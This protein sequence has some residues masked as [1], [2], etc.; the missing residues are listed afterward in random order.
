M[1]YGNLRIRVCNYFIYAIFC[2]FITNLPAKAAVCQLQG[3][4]IVCKITNEA[5]C[6]QVNDYPYARNLFCPASFSSAQTMLN[7]LVPFINYA[8]KIN[9]TTFFEFYQTPPNPTSQTTQS[10]MTTPFS[11]SPLIVSGIVKGAGQPLCDLIAYVTSPGSP[12]SPIVNPLNPVPTTLRTFPNYFQ[13]LWAGNGNYPLTTFRSNSPFDPIVGGL[14]AAAA[15]GFVRDDPSVNTV[16]TYGPPNWRNEA[17]Y[18]GISGGGGGGWGAE[19]VIIGPKTSR[20]G[21]TVLSFGGGGGGGLS[22]SKVPTK[23]YLGS[24]G[25]GGIQFVHGLGPSYHGLG[26]GA[27]GSQQLVA[28][29]SPAI[30]SDIQYTYYNVDI[31]GKQ[32]KTNSYD[33]GTINTYQNEILNLQNK[34]KSALALGYQVILKGG[35]GMGAGAEYYD[36]KNNEISPHALSTQAGFRFR[37]VLTDSRASGVL[38]TAEQLVSIDQNAFYQKLGRI[39]QTANSLALKQCNNSYSNYAG[40]ICPAT[41]A[42]TICLAQ[43]AL[44]KNVNELPSWLGTLYCPS[45][46]INQTPV[47]SAPISELSSALPPTISG[48]NGISTSV[49][50]QTKAECVKVITDY[51]NTLNAPVPPL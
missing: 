17:G 45:P 19:L 23:T 41:Q 8:N 50:S 36:V 42:L 39:Y 35:G 4:Q 13:I 38:S 40:C 20:T 43:V 34:I 12:V 2:L 16:S 29:I 1:K 27:G 48:L 30:K 6:L 3:S 37:Y 21:V 7:T 28:P 47:S 14:G 33:A 18:Y 31:N 49:I 9:I 10:C 24:G 32:T 51:F 15:S 5:D 25:G 26:L 11:S 46:T 22:S 44:G